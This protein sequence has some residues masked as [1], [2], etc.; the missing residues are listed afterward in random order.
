MILFRTMHL[1]F[2]KWFKPLCIRSKLFREAMRTA[3]ELSDI[4]FA[5]LQTCSVSISTQSRPG[6]KLCIIK[7]LV[8]LHLTSDIGPWKT[9]NQSISVLISLA[10][11]SL[12]GRDSIRRR[13][14]W[15]TPAGAREIRCKIDSAELRS[16]NVYKGRVVWRIRMQQHSDPRANRTHLRSEGYR[17]GSIIGCSRKT[18]KVPHSHE[19][20]SDHLT[21]GQ[22]SGEFMNGKLDQSFFQDSAK[23]NRTNVLSFGQDGCWLS[24]WFCFK[25]WGNVIEWTGLLSRPEPGYHLNEP[26]SELNEI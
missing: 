13:F 26:V 19:P 7:F 17:N 20:L 14:I 3:R 10:F 18:F 25:T 6:P 1:L 12:N 4:D 23:C 11:I 16:L 15:E 22:S 24:Q 9:L 8:T 21:W 5:P 2:H